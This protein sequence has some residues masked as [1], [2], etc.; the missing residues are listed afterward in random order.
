[1]T[2]VVYAST[3]FPQYSWYVARVNEKWK[4]EQ[5]GKLGT[6]W[7]GKT[8]KVLLCFSE[9]TFVLH[10][11]CKEKYKSLIVKRVGK[12]DA[13]H[14]VVVA[15]FEFFPFYLNFHP[16]SDCSER[17]NQFPLAYLILH[18]RSIFGLEVVEIEVLK[19]LSSLG[20]FFRTGKIMSSLLSRNF[21]I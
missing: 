8:W 1:M 12:R 5:L 4:E 14:V 17:L 3:Q 15:L 6:W 13:P 10:R 18:P 9:T 2:M 11:W 20:F 21:T 19:A 7:V 16:L